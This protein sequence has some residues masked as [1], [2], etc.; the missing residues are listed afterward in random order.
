[1]RKARLSRSLDAPTKPSHNTRYVFPIRSA[2][3]QHAPGYTPFH[4]TLNTGSRISK[5]TC[6]TYVHYQLFRISSIVYW[7]PLAGLLS[8]SCNRR[9]RMSGEERRLARRHA[10]VLRNE[11]RVMRAVRAREHLDEGLGYETTRKRVW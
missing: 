6:P 5:K 10:H 2:L 8:L 11:H 3:S 7:F 9:S 1:M 4:F